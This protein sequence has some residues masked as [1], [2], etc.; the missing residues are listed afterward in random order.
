MNRVFSGSRTGT[1][2]SM[3]AQ[4]VY[5]ELLHHVG[6]LKEACAIP[7]FCRRVQGKVEWGDCVFCIYEDKIDPSQKKALNLQR[8]SHQGCARKATNCRYLEPR[9]QALPAKFAERTR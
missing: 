9:G 8:P 4:Y 1:M 6:L 5:T 3:I 7:F 2:T